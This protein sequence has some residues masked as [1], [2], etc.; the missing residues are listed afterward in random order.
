MTGSR[1]ER[2]EWRAERQETR[3]EGQETRAEGQ[4]T[5]AEGRESRV[6]SRGTIE[7]SRE[8]RV[9]G[10]EL[11]TLGIG[12]NCTGPAMHQ[13]FRP[14]PLALSSKLS[15]LDSYLSAFS[16]GPL[17]RITNTGTES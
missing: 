14:S 15:A 13:A 10:L 2:R 6:E 8:K 9:E 17:V 11:R 4:E 1:D 16:S 7:T 3:A 5:R 12:E